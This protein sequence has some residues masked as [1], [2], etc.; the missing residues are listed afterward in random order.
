M[1]DTRPNIVLTGFM[2]TG[3]STV[4]RQLA[5]RTGRTFVDVDDEIAAAHGSIPEIFEAMGEA[6]FRR[7]EREAVRAI[8]ARRNLVVATGG[9]T[10]LDDDNVVAFLGAEIFALAATPEEIVERVTADGRENR[11]LLAGAD[12]PLAKVERLLDERHGAYERFTTIDTTNTSVDAVVDAIISSVDEQTVETVGADAGSGD[13]SDS[14]EKYFYALIAGL[15]VIA[16]VVLIAV[17]SF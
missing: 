17:I 13:S 2:G 3:K 15:M 10:M 12:D 9:G 11:P 16:F 1:S 5:L 7:L 4:G 8:A 6:E 14:V